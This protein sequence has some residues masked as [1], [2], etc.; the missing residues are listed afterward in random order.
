MDPYYSRYLPP[1]YEI[2]SR[3]RHLD[4]VEEDYRYKKAKLE[5]DYRSDKEY[6]EKM[7]QSLKDREKHNR[8]ISLYLEDWANHLCKLQNPKFN[9]Y[10]HHKTNIC[11]YGHNC[12]KKSFC[13]YAHGVGELVGKY[14]YKW[15][16]AGPSC[17]N[18]NCAHSHSLEEW[19]KHNQYPKVT[20]VTTEV[21]ST[22]PK[23]N[24][25]KSD[26]EETINIEKAVKEM[27]ENVKNNENI[28]NYVIWKD[29]QIKLKN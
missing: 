21:K 13:N 20:E 2:E 10:S 23:A 25:P 1:Y 19:K 14:K 27:I 22:A 6:F 29:G 28:N 11:K 8:K 5:R 24:G 26:T 18:T 7:E 3:K 4:Q 17:T 15:C 16:K 12:K 9:Q